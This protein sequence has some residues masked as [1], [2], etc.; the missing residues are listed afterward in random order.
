MTRPRRTSLL[1]GTVLAALALS[2][3]STSPA[4]SQTADGPWA[5]SRITSPSS[6]TNPNPQITSDFFRTYNTTANRLT[7]VTA[8]TAPAGL[9][10]G[11]VST[12]GGTGDERQL[13]RE[14]GWRH[15]TSAALTTSC[16]GAYAV[17]VTAH[18]QERCFLCSSGWQN[19]ETHQLT[20]TLAIAAPAPSP[21]ATTATAADRSVTIAW[22]PVADA[23][24]DFLGYRVER[25]SA[26]GTTATIAQ[27][28]DRTASSFT[29][30]DPPAEGGTTTYRVFGRRAGPSGEVQ[31]TPTTATADVAAAPGEPGEPGDPGQ[32]GQPGGPGQPGDGPV[33]TS[34]G[35]G[36]TTPGGRSP[37]ITGGPGSTVRVPRVGT[38]SR[39]FFPPLLTPQVAGEDAGFDD[40]LPYDD[41]EPG[42]DDPVL[43]DD[44]LASSAFDE[45]AGRGLAVPLA[46]GL[47]LAVWA[48][49]LRFLAR[50]A[51]PDEGG[52]EYGYE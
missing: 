10:A 8:V 17:T 21:T 14:E 28:D 29:D 40:R 13:T 46:T 30:A 7:A 45:V 32:P 49:H 47:V 44:E 43:P 20:G 24:P 6:T 19:V 18:L 41:L 26:S 34:P 33:P 48:F 51:R 1:G 50:A 15:P 5:G 4:R 31:S 11:C 23:P 27:L 39:S 35:S 42:D 2:L 37:S 16:N 3:L 12:L 52:Y 9:P 38:P 22:T 25:V 36:V